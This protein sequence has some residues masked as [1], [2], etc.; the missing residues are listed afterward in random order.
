M[1]PT[2]KFKADRRACGIA[3]RAKKK[4]NQQLLSGLCTQREGRKPDVG[5]S[6]ERPHWLTSRWVNSLQPGAQWN[7][8]A[9]ASSINYTI[10]LGA[11]WQTMKQPTSS[12][13]NILWSNTIER[14][15]VVWWT[16]HSLSPYL[17]IFTAKESIMKSTLLTVLLFSKAPSPLMHSISTSKYKSRV[18]DIQRSPNGL[19]NS[20]QVPDYIL[21]KA[22]KQG[23]N[24]T[25]SL[26]SST[27]KSFS[28]CFPSWETL[29][30]SFS[31]P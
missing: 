17:H 14:D 26:E 16:K 12:S 20:Y 10:F 8:Q 31:F 5:V 27:F 4:E 21:W 24:Q 25:V 29:S 19:N 3:G 1:V 6:H 30:Y 15:A 22:A 11:T 28:S 2:G 9:L 23:V 7:C 13:I 18:Q